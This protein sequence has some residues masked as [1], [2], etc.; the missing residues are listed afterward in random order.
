MRGPVLPPTQGER[1]GRCPAPPQ[2]FAVAPQRHGFRT[3]SRTLDGGHSSPHPRPQLG[4]WPLVTLPPI[5][6]IP[7][8]CC[9]A[10]YPP[11]PLSHLSSCSG[12][13][14]WQT[15]PTISSFPRMHPSSSWPNSRQLSPRTLV[16]LLGVPQDP[17]PLSRTSPGPSL[18]SLQLMASFPKLP[19][20]Q[21]I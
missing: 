19:P 21:G 6:H 16:H 12:T 18:L 13:C 8:P 2:E 15:T 4:R 3:L 17:A 7:L 9:P 14:L 11:Y 20:L 10:F 5:P 1:P